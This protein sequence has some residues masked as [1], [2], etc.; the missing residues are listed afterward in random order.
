MRPVGEGLF[1]ESSTALDIAGRYVEAYNAKDFDSLRALLDGDRFQF[2]HHS[3]NAY[4]ADADAFVAM[5]ERMAKDI[6][7]DRRFLHIHAV[8]VVEDVVLLDAE[9]RGT[10]I[11]TIP[12]KF[13]A[14]VERVMRLK[15]MIVVNAGLITEIRDHDS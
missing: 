15:S 13:Q 1:A 2:S 8:H 11:V 3:R 9:W 6:F 12:G 7:P 10:P 5:L 4:A 14:G